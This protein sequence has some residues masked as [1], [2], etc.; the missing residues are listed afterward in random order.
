MEFPAEFLEQ[1]LVKHLVVFL[2]VL[3][4]ELLVWPLL[5]VQLG[6]LDHGNVPGVVLPEELLVQLLVKLLL[7]LPE[8]LLVKFQE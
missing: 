7:A 2:V 8:Q 6:L 1:H 5:E 3:L 4:L